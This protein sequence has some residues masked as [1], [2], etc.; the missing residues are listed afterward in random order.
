MAG[1]AN[2]SWWQYSRWMYVVGRSLRMNAPDATEL[3]ALRVF[4][5]YLWNPVA[6]T[7][8]RSWLQAP[9]QRKCVSI[10]NAYNG[11]IDTNPEH[12][13]AIMLQIAARDLKKI[14]LTDGE[15]TAC[16]TMFA[17]TGNRRYGDKANLV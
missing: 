2:A 15:K 4:L 7:G 3:A 8:T 10:D 9:F 6:Q 13:L 14:P 17:A 5:K 11:T 1:T 16:D 12:Q